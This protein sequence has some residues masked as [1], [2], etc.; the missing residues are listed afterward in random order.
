MIYL[1]VQIN[2][3]IEPALRKIEVVEQGEYEYIRDKYLDFAI[4]GELEELCK[5][6][7]WYGISKSFINEETQKS[8]E[9]MVHSSFITDIE[10]FL[11]DVPYLREPLKATFRNLRIESIL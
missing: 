2:T 6:R 1:R 5:K 8:G 4:D 10:G 3:F 9:Y 11:S 7:G